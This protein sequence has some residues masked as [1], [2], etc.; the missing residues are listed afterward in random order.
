MRL[1]DAVRAL[2]DETNESSDRADETRSRV[3]AKLEQSRGRRSKRLFV[4]LPIAAVLAAATASAG[5]AGKLPSAWH[6]AL[7]VLHLSSPAPSARG[8]WRPSGG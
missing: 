3:V 1:E 8:G 7:K 4:I 5:V 6:S 2:R